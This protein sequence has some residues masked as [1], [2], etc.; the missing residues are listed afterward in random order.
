M[1]AQIFS[2]H[3]ALITSLFTSTQPV[4]VADINNDG[5][6]DIVRLNS[7]T[8]EV[9]YQQASGSFISSV[10]STQYFPWGMCIADIDRN[11]FNDILY[12]GQNEG[13]SSIQAVMM[14]DMGIPDTSIDI[15][16]SIF[17]QGI[18]F[19][20]INLDGWIDLYACHDNAANKTLL[21]PSSSFSGNYA[22]NWCDYDNDGDSDVY[23]SKCRLG[24]SDPT[25]P[26]RINLLWEN[27][28]AGSFI[29]VAPARNV[30]AGNQSWS[31]DFAD[32]DNDGDMDLFVLNHTGDNN[33]YENV[34][35]NGEHTFMDIIASTGLNFPTDFDWQCFFEDFDNDGYVDLLITGP[36]NR[37]FRNNGNKTF[38]PWEDSFPGSFDIQNAAIGDLNHDGHLD[39]YATY[40]SWSNPSSDTDKLLLNN[41]N[42]NN[43][44]AIRLTGTESNINAVGARLELFGSWGKQIREVNAGQGYGIMNTMT[45]HFGIGSSTTIDSLVVKWPNGLSTTVKDITPNQFIHVTE[46][47]DF[48]DL[49]SGIDDFGSGSTASI[50]ANV[51]ISASNTIE[52]NSNISY[53]G[54]SYVDLLPLFEIKETSAFSASIKG[55]VE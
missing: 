19:F 1:C 44:L 34:I 50:R 54:G 27:Q 41:G 35:V 51:G 12:G 2:D 3:T 13:S 11:G 26:R 28:G 45:Q 53:L 46:C 10:I 30:D 43:W 6:D 4:G 22:S 9:Q 23:I 14:D 18:N 21:M 55:C 36:N 40:G 25:N 20:D 47:Q 16:A 42:E 15:P 31:A 52:I 5:L 33:M 49:I 39:I 29:E 17:V 8:L 32:I 37:L 48:V 7:S 38:R 24:I